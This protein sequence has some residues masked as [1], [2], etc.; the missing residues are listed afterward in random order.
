MTD[1]PSLSAALADRYRL[2]RQP[3]AGGMATVYL[4]YDD[5]HGRDVA[6]KVLRPDLAESLG[7][8]RY[9]RE[10][11]LAARL[12][13]PHILPLYD[14]GEAGGFLY[15]V[16]PVMQE[17]TLRERLGTGARTPVDEPI[18]IAS[19]VADAL[20]YAHRHRDVKSK[21]VHCTKV[22]QPSKTSVSVRR[23]LLPHRQPPTYPAGG[24]ILC[25]HPQRE[26]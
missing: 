22:V 8:D 20:D 24:A 9:L 21:N 12:N 26:D 6:I 14:S 10:I 2:D 19:E 23:W 4:A 17:Q 13:H 11:R 3:G 7:H 16:M 1:L 25:Q 15:F 18:R 5:K